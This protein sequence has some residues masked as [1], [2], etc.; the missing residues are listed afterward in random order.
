MIFKKK[1]TEIA[2]LKKIK[3]KKIKIKKEKIRLL[4]EQCLFKQ[5]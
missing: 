1:N 5:T 3:Y 4:K 2:L